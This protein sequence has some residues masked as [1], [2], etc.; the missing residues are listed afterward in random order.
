MSAEVV[1]NSIWQ[2]F[3]IVG[4]VGRH[5]HRLM[6]DGLACIVSVGVEG[7]V[8]VPRNPCLNKM[9]E[10]TCVSSKTFHI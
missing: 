5:C 7:F 2:A 1:L 8:S 4:R 6:D 3:D 10:F 9:K